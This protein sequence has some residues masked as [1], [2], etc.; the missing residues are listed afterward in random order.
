M[1]TGRLLRKS[2]VT[3]RLGITGM[4]LYRWVK[5]GEFPPPLRLGERTTRWPE[6]EIDEW[7]ASRRSAEHPPA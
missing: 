1:T 7:I 6:S 4:T 3:E 2:E 5:K